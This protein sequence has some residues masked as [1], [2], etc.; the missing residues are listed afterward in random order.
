ML[1]TG[2]ADA[3]EALVVAVLEDDVD[4]LEELEAEELPASSAGGSELSKIRPSGEPLHP[5]STIIART[6]TTVRIAH[7]SPRSTADRQRANLKARFPFARFS[8][9]RSGG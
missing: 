4:E 8:D 9:G 2:S 1:V 6:K 7:P 3:V 5:S